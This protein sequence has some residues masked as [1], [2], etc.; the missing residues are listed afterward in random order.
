[1][2]YSAAIGVLTNV[3][4][5]ANSSVLKIDAWNVSSLPYNKDIA[6][7]DYLLRSLRLIGIPRNSWIDPV[8]I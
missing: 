5:T 8:D 7:V 1:M 4:K 6:W 2:M 3:E